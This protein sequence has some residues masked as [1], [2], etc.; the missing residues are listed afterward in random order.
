MP[1]KE[2][3][4]EQEPKEVYRGE[5]SSDDGPMIQP[6]TANPTVLEKYAEEL[7]FL[8]EYVEVMINPS[9]DP[10]DTTRLVDGI[11]CNGQFE[12]FMRGEWKKVKRKFLYSLATAKPVS[13]QF[14]IKMGRDGR[15]TNT[16]FAASVSRFPFQV[17]DQNPKGAAWLQHVLEQ[18]L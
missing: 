12:C 17:R 9:T 2:T 3:R 4:V 15:P 13:Y 7:A 1:T 5:H 11:G 14:G 18:P 10:R 8:E 16:D 6:F